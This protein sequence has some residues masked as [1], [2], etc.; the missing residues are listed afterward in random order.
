[1]HPNM[2]R[3]AFWTAVASIQPFHIRS[4][5]DAVHGASVD[6]GCITTARL[7]EHEYQRLAESWGC[8]T[9]FNNVNDKTDTQR[10]L[11]TLRKHLRALKRLLYDHDTPEL[12]L[13]VLLDTHRIMMEGESDACPGA[14]RTTPA[15]AN[16]CNY[17]DPEHVPSRLAAVLAQ[18]NRDNAGWSEWGT[19]RDP[20]EVA[21]RLFYDLI[22]C[23]H[24][25]VD[26]N[27][28]MGRLLV[29]FVLMRSGFTQFA[30][31]F[32]N[33]HSKPRKHYEKAILHFSRIHNPTAMLS[34]F[35]LECAHHYWNNFQMLSMAHREA[36][37]CPPQRQLI[38]PHSVNNT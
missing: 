7:E 21:A 29:S 1:M 15:S 38:L 11:E 36:H 30:L 13:D 20:T 12:T 4:A 33:G 35:I 27:G 14:L 10:R 2:C 16:G 17:L 37:D 31:P 19:T 18:Y 8:M 28:R 6:E 9:P 23:I 22:H 24:P 3:F 25:F 26:G 5:I 32:N 34:L